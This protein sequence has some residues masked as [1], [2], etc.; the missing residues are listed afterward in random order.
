MPIFDQ[1]YQNWKGPLSSHAWRWFTIARHGVRVM[2]KNRF[3]FI[4]VLLAT[5]LP[6]IGLVA[7]VAVWGLIEQQSQTVLALVRFLPA[8]ILGDPRSYRTAFWTISYSLFFRTQMFFIMF[9][10]VVAGPGL[11]SRDL[12]FNALPLYFARPLTRLDYFLGKLGVIGALVG[13]VAVVP[14]VLAYVVGVCF[15]LDLG[16]VKDT[17]RVLLASIAYGLVITLSAGTLI[18]AMSSLT[19]RSLYVG[20]AFAGMWLISGTVGPIMTGIY[21]ESERQVIVED[22]LNKWVAENPPPPGMR[23]RGIYPSQEWNPN[24]KVDP[25]QEKEKQRWIQA[26]SEAWQQARS[27]AEELQTDS[28]KSDWRP[29]LSYVSNLQRLGDQLLDT[30]GAWVTIGKAAEKPRAM[31]G[32]M[33][34]PR[35]KTPPVNEHR[36]ANLWVTQYPWVWSAGLLAAILGL[37]IWTLSRR[38]KS[39]DRL[40]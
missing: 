28:L 27:D 5:I 11:I 38:V 3:L 20:I 39:L 4:L 40:K 34:G 32:P 10:V 6:A 33:F 24:K 17:Y 7:A 35:G 36:L 30:E 18:L 13:T 37:S 22:T 14:A 31:F 8:D 2:M 29:L 25:A 23:M 16:V 1:G 26:W 21:H 12:R 19:R 9:L 15:S